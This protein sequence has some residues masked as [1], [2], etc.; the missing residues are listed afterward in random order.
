M[1]GKNLMMSLD[2]KSC[3]KIDQSSIGP[4]FTKVS[5]H[6]KNNPDAYSHLT[7]KII[8]GGSGVWG[9]V[10]MPAHPDLKEADARQIV[11]WVLSLANTANQKKSLLPNGEILVRSNEKNQ[12]AVFVLRAAY[13]DNGGVG[14]RPLSS[15]Q[16]VYLRN[17]LMDAADVSG[18]SG[19]TSIDSSGRKFYVFPANSGFIKVNQLDLTG[20][21]SIEVNGL[22]R[23]A[24]VSYKIEIR[25][26]EPNGKKIG[27]SQISFTG[28]KRN[29]SAEV[30]LHKVNDG[31]LHDIYIVCTV[32]TAK[33]RAP[34]L[35]SI[36][37]IPY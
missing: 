8:K 33:G 6:Y 11:Q 13:T 30:A 22:G 21:G 29:V 17:S 15:T 2:C 35:K 32:T 19:F 14:I 28:N 4:A 5:L 16:A 24:A 26:G 27:E 10:A 37:F 23:G 31:K 12:N 25:T 34:L 3:H 1:M 20:I 18:A 9:E 7:Q 36:K